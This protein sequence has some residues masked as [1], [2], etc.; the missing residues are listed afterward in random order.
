MSW[1]LLNDCCL[2]AFKNV[3]SRHTLRIV[4]KQYWL[5]T[6]LGHWIGDRSKTWK[7]SKSIRT[8]AKINHE[9]NKQS[10][11]FFL[12]CL[13]SASEI[14]SHL[15]TQNGHDCDIW[16]GSNS[17]FKLN[18]E[19]RLQHGRTSYRLTIS[20]SNRYRF[21]F[22]SSFPAIKPQF[23]TLLFFSLVS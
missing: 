21:R 7:Q 11:A 22:R 14:Y 3:Y 10:R 19:T 9:E 6:S 20:H 12:I 17:F 1:Y 2:F 15:S 16:N 23:F 8:V 18:I 5:R 4:K 13:E